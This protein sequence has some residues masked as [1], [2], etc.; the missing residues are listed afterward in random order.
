MTEIDPVDVHVGHRL[1]EMRTSHG[2][3]MEALGKRVGVSYQQIQKY[4]TGFNRISASMLWRIAGVLEIDVAYFFEGLDDTP[5]QLTPDAATIR[6]MAVLGRMDPL[7]R[8]EIRRLVVAL[9]A[10]GAA[11]NS[12]DRDKAT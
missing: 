7:V 10:S 1:R 12:L 4:E 5:C 6:T 2:M 9:A 8:Q 3:S 11:S